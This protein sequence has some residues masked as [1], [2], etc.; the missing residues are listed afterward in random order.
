M[1]VKDFKLTDTDK[2]A[3][4]NYN[5]NYINNK[6]ARLYKNDTYTECVEYYRLAA[7]MGNMQAVSNL[8]YCYLYGRNIDINV[9]L[10]IAYFKISADRGI[11]DS[12][13]K[14]GDIF[15]RDKWVKPDKEKALY[16]YTMAIGRIID[17]DNDFE[18]ID[19]RDV[20]E[21][22]RLYYNEKALRYPSL[23]FAVGRELKSGEMMN[24][25]LRES[26]E[27]LKI[28][29]K[30]YEFAIANGADMYK[31]SYENVLKLIEDPEFEEAKK[32]FENKYFP[33]DYENEEE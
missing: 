14:L 17:E 15:S 5:S 28:A 30:G 26:F 12:M 13:Y 27:F 31:E 22:L 8:G 9:D 3:I 2:E 4:M 19:Y 1:E 24:K 32:D 6:G 29:E 11:I 20:W 23:F 10:A 7:A 33:E 25:D 16:Y 21:S 18:D